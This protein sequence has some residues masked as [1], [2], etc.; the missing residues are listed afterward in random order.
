MRFTCEDIGLGGFVNAGVGSTV[1]ALTIGVF[2]LILCL[3]TI[4]HLTFDV[5]LIL[6]MLGLFIKTSCLKTKCIQS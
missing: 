6:C 2:W 4:L 5:V 1:L 3:I